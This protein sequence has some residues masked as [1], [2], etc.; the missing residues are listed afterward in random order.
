MVAFS[1]HRKFWVAHE[2][3]YLFFFG[4]TSFR[5]LS[6]D[7]QQFDI[8]FKISYYL[9]EC[10]H[11]VRKEKFMTQVKKLPKGKIVPLKN[12]LLFK[13]VFGDIDG[14]KRLEGFIA[15]YFNV[16]YN[17]VKGNVRILES[18]KR[19]QR[20]SDKRQS[21]DIIVE[22]ELISKKFKLNIEMNLKEG[23]TLYRNF[24]YATN[25]LGGYDHETLQKTNLSCSS[26][27]SIFFFHLSNNLI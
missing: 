22:V 20:K 5:T 15:S 19:I 27:C 2:L 23:T 14:I 10:I 16:P 18:E 11:Y 9:T 7:D 8:L 24:I 13:K 6:P 12:D 4:S 3:S 1:N 21:V 17:E 25:F 26:C